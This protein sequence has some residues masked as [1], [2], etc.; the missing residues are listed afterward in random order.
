[1]KRDQDQCGAQVSHGRCVA[2]LGPVIQCARRRRLTL[3]GCAPDRVT[4]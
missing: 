4:R 1:L 3:P 2:L